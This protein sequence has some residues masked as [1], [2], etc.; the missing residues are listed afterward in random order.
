[1][2]LF[3]LFIYFGGGGFW[4]SELFL[5]RVLLFI[6]LF[7]RSFYLV[8]IFEFLVCSFLV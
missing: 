6:G 2:F 7:F 8:G 5:R 1:M 3:D 4:K